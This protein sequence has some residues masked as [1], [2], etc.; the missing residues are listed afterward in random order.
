MASLPRQISIVF[1]LLKLSFKFHISYVNKQ[2]AHLNRLLSSSSHLDSLLSA[3]YYTI[4]FL[5]S[6]PPL[7]VSAHISLRPLAGLISTLRT[8]LRLSGLLGIYSWALSVHALPPHTDRVLRFIAWTQVSANVVYQVLENGAFLADHGVL[9]GW[10][11]EWR[12]RWWRWS[13]R[14]WMCHVGLEGARLGREWMLELRRKETLQRMSEGPGTSALGEESG[15]KTL[16]MTRPE[17]SNAAF[18]TEDGEKESKLQQRELQWNQQ[19]RWWRQAV[20]NGAFFPLT[21]HSSMD[22]G[23]LGDRWVGLLGMVAA[24]VTLRQAWRET[25]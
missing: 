14:A 12:Q 9:K 18:V 21:L 25:A 11:L 15:A 5:T 8:T 1:R 2:I 6:F 4:T 3:L 24:E 23:L 22:E 7:C 19:Q 13:S 17:K 16:E 20:V 10:S